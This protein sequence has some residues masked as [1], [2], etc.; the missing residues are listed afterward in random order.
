[1][2]SS[3][4]KNIIVSVHGCVRVHACVRACALAHMC[5]SVCTQ[6]QASARVHVR[7]RL[8]VCTCDFVCHA[9]VYNVINHVCHVNKHL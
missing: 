5:T 6:K 1:M 8:S 2:N 4:T 9:C 7:G 3:N